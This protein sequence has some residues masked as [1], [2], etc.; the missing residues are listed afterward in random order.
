M[1]DEEKF[2]AKQSRDFSKKKKGLIVGR[3][4]PSKNVKSLLE[5]FLSAKSV[6]SLEKILV[7]GEPSKGNEL[8]FESLMRDYRSAIQSNDIEFIGARNQSELVKI[9]E[10]SDFLL[11]GFIGSLD[12]VLVESAL[13]GLPVISCNI[14]FIREFGK[15][16]RLEFDDLRM[17]F[18]HI[19][20]VKEE[21]LAFL[22]A[23]KDAVQDM[24][25]KRRRVA[26]DQHSLKS[27]EKKFV[28]GVLN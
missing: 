17:K 9:M 22:G 13:L 2:Y 20:T 25:E 1:V 15:F 4:D 23:S 26:L 5:V 7:V 28:K 10:E 19:N 14:G 3:I 16:S 21:F 27:W 6:F 18:D 24:T 8:Y 11:H 12:K